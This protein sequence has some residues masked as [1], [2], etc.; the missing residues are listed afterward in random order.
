[1]AQNGPGDPGNWPPGGPPT[2]PFAAYWTNDIVSVL[3]TSPIEWANPDLVWVEDGLPAGADTGLS[4]QQGAGLAGGSSG[5]G[6][7]EHRA[8]WGADAI[9]PPAQAGANRLD[10][11][12][13]P[14]AGQWAQLAI[15]AEAVDL[16]GQVVEGMAFTLYDG[17]AAWDRVGRTRPNPAVTGFSP[18]TAGDMVLEPETQSCYS[19]A[20]SPAGWW[21]AEGNTNDQAGLD[22]GRWQGT[23]PT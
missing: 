5:A 21:Q 11:G 7:W 2:N 23:L 9:A 1:L 8:Y 4:A 22:N 13:L 18:A 10:A 3:G 6:S 14:P 17:E 12:P 15:P 20:P 19:P 16:A